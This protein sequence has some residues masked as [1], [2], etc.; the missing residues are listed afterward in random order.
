MEAKRSSGILCSV[1]SELL[2]EWL[3]VINTSGERRL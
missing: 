2:G 1:S 3:G